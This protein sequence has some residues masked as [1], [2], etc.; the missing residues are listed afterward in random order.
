MAAEGGATERRAKSDRLCI[1]QEAVDPDTS[2]EAQ[3]EGRGSM[4]RTPSPEPTRDNTELCRTKSAM[5]G[6]A[7]SAETPPRT[8]RTKYQKAIRAKMATLEIEAKLEQ[9]RREREFRERMKLGIGAD[10]KPLTG[11]PSMPSMDPSRWAELQRQYMQG[12]PGPAT[13]PGM[14]PS[15]LL[16]REQM[17]RERE[18]MDRLGIPPPGGALGPNHMSAERLHIERMM[19]A[20]PMTRFSMYPPGSATAAMHAHM[21]AHSHTHLHVHDPLSQPGS[22]IPPGPPHGLHM[23][24]GE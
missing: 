8:C 4:R 12:G 16:E 21:H 17:E 23:I 14:I 1:K 13:I 6:L 11:H 20:D 9:E 3:E 22:G 15:G 7:V 24:P 10:G 2:N 5:C 18:R 19:A